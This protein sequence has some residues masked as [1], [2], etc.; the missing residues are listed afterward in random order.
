MNNNTPL[1][2]REIM[3]ECCANCVFY[4]GGCFCNHA[5]SDGFFVGAYPIRSICDNYIDK[6]ND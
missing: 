2:F 4:S 3:T 1:N 5:D 6:G